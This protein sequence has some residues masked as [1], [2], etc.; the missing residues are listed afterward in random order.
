MKKLSARTLG[1]LKLI[2]ESQGI[3]TDGLKRVEIAEAIEASGGQVITSMNVNPSGTPS[4][5]SATTNDS[6][7]L[8]SPQPEKI[9]AKRGVPS[10]EPSPVQE[11]KV[12]VYAL[13]NLS[14]PGV[15]KL[16][17]GYNFVTKEVADKWLQHKAVREASPEE[18]A[19]HFGVA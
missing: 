5:T 11:N 17:K 16:D 19:S 10:E 9:K 18:V 2:A 13:R 6:G 8:I 4:Q 14:W 3:N 12:A 7:V 1:E 15:G